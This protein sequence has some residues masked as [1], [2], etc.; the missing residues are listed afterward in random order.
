ML[1]L[2]L[3]G[4]SL[5]L[6]SSWAEA[7]GVSAAPQ[8]VPKVLLPALPMV[9]VL[10]PQLKEQAGLGQPHG[11]TQSVQ[12]LATSGRRV[13]LVPVSLYWLEAEVYL[14]GRKLQ[15]SCSSDDPS[16]VHGLCKVFCLCVM[17][18]NLRESYL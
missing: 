17:Y 6:V 10:C 7:L 3:P 18:F 15:I 8:S 5:A 12:I 13:N 4:G 9:P 16:C 1:L 2:P 14:T 11:F